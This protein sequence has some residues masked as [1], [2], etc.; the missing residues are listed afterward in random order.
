MP[1]IRGKSLK[2]VIRDI[3]DG[4]VVVNPLFLK[5]FDGET[6]RDFYGEISRVQ[7][8]V[9]AE[10][11][12]HNDIMAIRSRNLKLQ[13]LFGATMIIRNFAKERRIQLTG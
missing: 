9:R 5:S 13:R 8:E 1:N 10:K 11:F 6:L 12:P 7:N 4:Y 2:A 3:A